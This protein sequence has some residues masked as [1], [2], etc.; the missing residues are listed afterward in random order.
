M[1]LWDA[2]AN[3]I[4]K[5]ELSIRVQVLGYTAVILTLLGIIIVS[6]LHQGTF[7]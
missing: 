5:Q 3:T 2:M 6:I 4:Q 1:S 7:P